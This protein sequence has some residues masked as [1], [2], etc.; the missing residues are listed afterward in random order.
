MTSSEIGKKLKEARLA[1]KMTQ[2]EVVGNFITRNMLSQIES[3]AAMPSIKTLEYLCGVLDIPLATMN[4]DEYDCSVD[5]ASEYIKIREMYKSGDFSGVISAD[6]LNKEFCEEIMFI[7]ARSYYNLANQLSETK[8]VMDMQRAVE[9]FKNASK[10]CV[11]L[12]KSVFS[13][14]DILSGSES[15][16]KNLAERLSAYYKSLI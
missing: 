14:L 5:A 15:H 7:K 12:D 2:S 9:F 10:L 16:I 11:K 3:G 6:V 8:N 4:S 1:K 13:Y